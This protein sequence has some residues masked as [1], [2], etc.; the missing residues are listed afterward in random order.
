MVRYADK[1]TVEVT[2]EIAAAPQAVW[3]LVTDINLPARFSDE[4]QGAEWLDGASPA[5][6]ARFVGRNGH[7]ATGEWETTCTVMWFEPERT[8]GYVVNDVT[9]PAA[10]WRFDLTP[11][12]DGTRLTMWAEMGPGRSGITY[13]IHKYPERE[14]EIVANRLLEWQ[15]N[16][17]ATVAGIKA[18]A[19]AADPG[20]I[21]A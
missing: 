7:A 16:M 21:R 12:G 5:R 15:R 8:F 13:F 3:S 20:P 19:E 10:S 14:E 9:D 2:A 18:L 6:G 17:Q 11:S 1:P 4:F